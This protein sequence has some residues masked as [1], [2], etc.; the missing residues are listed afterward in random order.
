[1]S[2]YDACRHC[3]T[4]ATQATSER[5]RVRDVH[6]YWHGKFVVIM[7]AQHVERHARDQVV[8]RLQGHFGRTVALIRDAA[9]ERWRG[10]RRGQRRDA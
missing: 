1:M 9:I 3:R 7:A 8:F 6:M 2:K 10:R 5:N 4:G